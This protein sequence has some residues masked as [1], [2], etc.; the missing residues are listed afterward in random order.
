MAGNGSEETR[1]EI[2]SVG[3]EGNAI[4]S[5]KLAGGIEASDS[6]SETATVNP[7]DAAREL[8]ERVANLRGTG[9][10]EPGPANDP[11][12]PFG[13]HADGTP[14]KRRPYSPRGTGAKTATEK[15]TVSVRGIEKL[16]YSIHQM[17][18][19]MLSAPE[20][21]LDEKESR[22]LANAIRDVQEHYSVSISPKAEAWA[23]L[24][25]VAV[26]L[27]GTRAVAIASRVSGE[28]AER[29]KKKTEE[30]EAAKTDGDLTGFGAF[31]PT[32]L[33]PAGGPV[34]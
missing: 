28:R 3:I 20:L 21:E 15:S 1:P 6:G 30:K 14:R 13:R 12:A 9:H 11:G 34:N 24:A 10:A 8:R 25:V 32:H 27:Y 5:E 4:G 17:G 29:R 19:A 7:A 26:G 33:T 22:D 18:A 31:V 23:N 2:G 16:L